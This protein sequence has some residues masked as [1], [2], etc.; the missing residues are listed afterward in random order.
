MLDADRLRLIWYSGRKLSNMTWVEL[1]DYATLL[2]ERL[3]EKEEEERP[4]PGVSALSSDLL[5]MHPEEGPPLPRAFN[6]KWPWR[7][8]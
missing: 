2:K 8:Y 1:E 7:K 6:L 4:L 3:K 5:P